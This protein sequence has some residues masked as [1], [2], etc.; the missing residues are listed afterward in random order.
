[1][2]TIF[3]NIINI[4]NNSKF[5]STVLTIIIIIAGI[6]AIVYIIKLLKDLRLYIVNKSNSFYLANQK[7]TSIDNSSLTMPERIELTNSILDLISFMVNNEIVSD[8]KTYVALNTSYDISKL[9][10]DVTTISQ[11]VFDGINK[12]LFKDPNLILTETYLMEFITKKT[13]NTLLDVAQT[14]NSNLRT[15]NQ[16]VGD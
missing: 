10:D 12:T 8:F 7:N 3:T 2:Q 6:S 9:D 13:I 4:I 16:G 5:L 11:R 14:H 1:M 15:R